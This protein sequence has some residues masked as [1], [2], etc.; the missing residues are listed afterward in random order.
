MITLLDTKLIHIRQW[1]S[2]PD[3]SVNYHKALTL[4]QPNTNAGQWLLKSDLFEQW[5][6]K[7]STV[8]LH[9]IPGC[10]KTILCSTV[11][12]DILNDT[13][14]DPGKAVAYFYFDFND[15]AKQDPNLMMRSLISQLSQQCVKIPPSLDVLFTSCG[16]GQR[17]PS[18]DLLPNALQNLLQEFPHTYIILDALDECGSRKLLMSIIKELSIGQTSGLHLLCTSRREGDIEATLGHIVESEGILCIQT[19]AV[20]HDIRSYVHQRLSNDISL[21]KW[22][23]DPAIRQ[24]IETT[25]MA[26]AHGMYISTYLKITWMK[27]RAPSCQSKLCCQFAKQKE[28]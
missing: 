10:G 9:G 27:G 21:K 15:P 22:G 12:E 7:A 19:E 16:N 2:A 1:L 6:V 26:G 28:I 14:G 24:E 13:T 23:D 5:K 11:I 8:W 18:P 3:P 25:L 17:Q 4:R 20:D